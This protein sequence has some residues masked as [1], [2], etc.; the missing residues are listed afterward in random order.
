MLRIFN[1]ILIILILNISARNTEAS[2][3]FGSWSPDEKCAKRFYE[4]MTTDKEEEDDSMLIKAKISYREK[5]YE[6]AIQYANQTINKHSDEARSMQDSLEE[7]PWISKED[8]FRYKSLN[9]IGLALFIKAKSY[10]ELGKMREAEDA[11]KE[12][13][14]DYYYAQC[15]CKEG[16]FLKPA[17][18]AQEELGNIEKLK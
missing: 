14:K 8:I 9:T 5:R 3:F 10:S 6:K 2:S 12:L 17:N 16:L 4:L 18:L 13:K 7:Y 11:L 1:I 15:W